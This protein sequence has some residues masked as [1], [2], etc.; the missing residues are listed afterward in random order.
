MTDEER[1]RFWEK[2]ANENA[3]AA[4]YYRRELAKAHALLGRVVHQVSER[5]DRLNLT[6]YFPTNNRYGQRSI[7]NPEGKQ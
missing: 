6:E 4:D 7:T 1:A 3:A 5:W 2:R